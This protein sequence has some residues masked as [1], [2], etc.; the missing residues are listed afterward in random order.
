MV[1]NK[2]DLEIALSLFKIEEGQ[3]RLSGDI[4]MVFASI[5]V[6]AL[7]LGRRD[8]LYF[9]RFNKYLTQ[10]LWNIY[11]VLHRLNWQRILW[12]DDRLPD[13]LWSSY[14]Q[15]DINLFHVEFRSAMDYIARII[16]GLPPN[17]WQT[18]GSYHDLMKWIQK[19]ENKK[20]IDP[21]VLNILESTVWFNDIRDLRD[22]NVHEGGFLLVFG[23]KG[24]ITFQTYSGYEKKVQIPEL[25]FNE[26]IVDF[27]L[28]AGLYL[29]YLLALY[30]KLSKE[31]K[32]L[33]QL[34]H[35][36][37][38]A[39]TTHF[40]LEYVRSLIQSAYEL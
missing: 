12:V 14:A 15:N 13:L 35:G 32:R 3:L 31:I 5:T 34:K 8:L 16:R 20:I 37:L 2:T 17:P 25:M 29:G 30:E 4:N 36:P 22:L 11:S 10:D 1:I 24:H 9:D 26:N 38:G 33:L 6:E 39:H 28:Y 23:S 18:P 21:E 19:N 27:E 7:S 40:G